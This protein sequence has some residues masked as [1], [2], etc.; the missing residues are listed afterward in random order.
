MRHQLHR[1]KGKMSD[2]DGRGLD[3]SVC[4]GT[5]AQNGNQT[6]SIF[7]LQVSLNR[8]NLKKLKNFRVGVCYGANTEA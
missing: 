2:M 4:K 5:T 3:T 8:G 1:K 6:V 7:S